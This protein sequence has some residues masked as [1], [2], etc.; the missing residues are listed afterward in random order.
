MIDYKIGEVL[1]KFL[2]ST[3]LLENAAGANAK[4][5]YAAGSPAHNHKK[6]RII[7]KRVGAKCK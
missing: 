6:S 1:C 2:S 4:A 5:L 3:D 7:D